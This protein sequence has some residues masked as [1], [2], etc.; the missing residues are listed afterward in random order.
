[1][2]PGTLRRILIVRVDRVGD[3]VLSTPALRALRRAL[4]AAKIDY[5]VQ[6]KYARPLDAYEGWNEVVRWNDID[7][8]A[9]RA[10]LAKL[11]R[12]RG[13]D[14]AVIGST[15]PVGYRVAREAG[16]PIRVG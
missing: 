7:D 11:L 10:T 9:E 12:G 8:A 1:P 16:I 2:P 4:P 15:A 14:A 6:A 3:I 13:Y 5:L